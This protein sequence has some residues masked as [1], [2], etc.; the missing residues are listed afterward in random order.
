MIVKHACICTSN[1]RYKET[2]FLKNLRDFEPGAYIYFEP[3]VHARD[4]VTSK[5]DISTP[6][7]V[8]ALRPIE[9]GCFGA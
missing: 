7:D 6:G 9:N 5:K 3:G 2:F 8:G 4:A 1:S